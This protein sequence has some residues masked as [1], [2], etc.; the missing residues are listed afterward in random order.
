MYFR[1]LFLYTHLVICFMF[2]K[3]REESSHNAPGEIT[4]LINL[5][6]V[7]YYLIFKHDVFSN[8]SGV[9]MC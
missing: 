1:I 9:Q 4:C 3:Q 5:V 7:F 6:Q 2:Y 8:T